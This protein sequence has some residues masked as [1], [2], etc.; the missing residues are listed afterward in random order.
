MVAK[1]FAPFTTEPEQVGKL[2]ITWP[3]GVI[4]LSHVAL[5]VAPDDP[6]YGQVHPHKEGF[7]FLGKIAIQGER[8]LLKVSTDWVLRLRYNPFYDY[9]ESRSLDW[10]SGLNG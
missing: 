2:E 1:Y 3:P 6:V 9:L 5:P 8:G 4:S 7:I 10:I